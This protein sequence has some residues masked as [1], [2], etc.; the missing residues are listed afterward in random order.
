M[1]A[2][3]GDTATYMQYAHARICGIFRKGEVD[4][5][6]LR[7][8][9]SKITVTH[10]TERALVLQLLRF[11]EAMNE[12]IVDYRPNLLTSYLFETANRFSTF[13]D[14]C[15]VLK[16]EDASTRNSRLLLCDVTG[17]IIS[18]GLSLLGIDTPEIM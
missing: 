10:P 18:H 17:R 4:R 9:D 5:T 3:T 11:S 14:V 1:L 6:A 15:N 13:Y 7:S 16:E 12:V 2:T 8:A